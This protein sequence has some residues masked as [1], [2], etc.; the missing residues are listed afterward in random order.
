MPMTNFPS[1]RQSVS[2]L[3]YESQELVEPPFAAV[4]GKKSFVYDF[5]NL[6]HHGGILD[7]FYNAAS[8]D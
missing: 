2:V 3:V 4:I 1:F 7:L 8:F 6:L 5:I